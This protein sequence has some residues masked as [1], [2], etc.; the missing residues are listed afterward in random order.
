MGTWS[1]ILALGIALSGIGVEAHHA[2]SAIYDSSKQVTVDG[3]VRDFQFVNPHPFVMMEVADGGGKVLEWRLELD[4]RFELV[5]IGVKADTLKI[6]DRV[7]V[8]GSLSRERPQNLYVMRLDRPAD[9]FRYEQIGA[10]PRIRQG[11]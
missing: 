10:S 1:S 9:G 4:N 8:T 5:G 11:R 7:I 3:V 2:I 6:G